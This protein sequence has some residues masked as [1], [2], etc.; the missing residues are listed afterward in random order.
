MKRT[1]G[2]EGVERGGEGVGRRDAVQLLAFLPGPRERGTGGTVSLVWKRHRDRGQL[3]FVGSDPCWG[4]S[5]VPGPKSEAW[6][7]ASHR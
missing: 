2:Q 6:G 1:V 5:A 4:V 3:P 7:T